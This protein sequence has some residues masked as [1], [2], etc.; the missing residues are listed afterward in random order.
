M[1]IAHISLPVGSHFVAMRDFYVAI[2]KPLGYEVLLGNAEGQE[3]VGLGRKAHGANFFLGLGANTKTLPKYDG[4]LE[5]RIA[6][7]HLAF[8]ATGPEQVN[9][10]HEAAL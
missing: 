10:W 7:F 4:K 3:F 8:D 9:E 2:L 5:S 6:P 1:S